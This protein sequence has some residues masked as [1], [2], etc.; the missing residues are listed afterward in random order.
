MFLEVV[1]QEHLHTA[2]V[3]S[4]YIGNVFPEAADVLARQLGQRRRDRLEPGGG[5]ADAAVGTVGR[6]FGRDVIALE[7]R[8]LTVSIRCAPRDNQRI[9]RF[10]LIR[11]CTKP[12]NGARRGRRRRVFAGLRAVPARATRRVCGP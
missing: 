4:V 12:L 9:C 2:R 5:H 7:R 1:W 3:E 6:P 8:V 11:R 10:A